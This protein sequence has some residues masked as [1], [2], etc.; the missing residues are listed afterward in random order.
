[1][2]QKREFFDGLG[3]ESEGEG[4]GGRREKKSRSTSRVG[5]FSLFFFLSEKALLE[6]HWYIGVIPVP[7]AMH[8]TCFHLFVVIGIF[9]IGPF[10]SQ[11]CPGSSA[12]SALL[13][14]PPS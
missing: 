1:M 6:T 7:P 8:P 14:F 4:E 11:V 5:F 9:G 2:G 10:I 3:R 13:I 12:Q